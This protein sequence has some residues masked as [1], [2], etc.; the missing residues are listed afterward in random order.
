MSSSPSPRP[1]RPTLLALAACCL[2]G[3]LALYAATAG[4]R[5]VST[6]AGR[7]LALERRPAPLPPTVV[8][9]ALD[10]RSLSL[11][12]DLAS[13]RRAAIV[14]FVYT[15]CQSICSVTGTEL[16]QLQARIRSRGLERRVR[17]LTISFDPADDG[18]ALTAYARRMGADPRL[19][20]F[21][22]IAD[23]A[24]RRRLLEVF[25]IVVVPAPP[26]DFVHNAAYHVIDRDGRLAR[27]VDIGAADA[28]L[29]TALRLGGGA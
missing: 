9:R 12:A 7:R 1:L 16:Q 11:G 20:R 5:V 2:T 6:E 10:G 22:G 17:L 23:A 21:Y 27:I 18:A 28:A 13:D 4:F 15:R 26:G 24:G 8:R 29:D 3:M 14:T 25:G 19:W